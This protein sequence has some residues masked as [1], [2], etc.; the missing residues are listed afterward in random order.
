MAP[1]ACVWLLTGEAVAAAFGTNGKRSEKLAAD[2]LMALEQRIKNALDEARMVVLVVQVLLGFQFSVVLERRFDRL[3][4]EGQVVHVVGLSLLLSAF[5]LAVSPATFHRIAEDGN[6]TPRV[7]RFTSRM[8]GLALLPFA[9]ALGSGLFV[10]VELTGTRGEA[11]LL[12]VS[13]FITALALW[14]GGP[15]L[16]RRHRSALARGS[17][18]SSEIASKIDHT[19]TEARMVLPGA[20]AVLGFQFMSF[21]AAGFVDLP[22]T[23]RLIHL[24][25]L[26][27][28]SLAGILLIAP[29]AFHRIAEEGAPTR[30]FYLYASGMVQA[31]LVPL[32]MGMSADFYVVVAKVSGSIAYAVIAAG[33]LLLTT[34]A[35]WWFVPMIARHR[36]TGSTRTV[37]GSA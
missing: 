13:G 35:L 8:V 9:A 32:A 23:S 30:R 14:Y 3:S 36:A 5:A 11:A 20:Q 25:G 16:R 26:V 2:I 4:F 22:P 21:F 10:V 34:F 24:V 12:G 37:R 6:D 19:L 7:L 31:S 33:A 17:Q 18:S 29:A 28:V 27:L 1:S 15:L